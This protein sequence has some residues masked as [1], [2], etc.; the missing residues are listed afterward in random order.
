MPSSWWPG[1][2][3]FPWSLQW[4]RTDTSR[5]LAESGRRVSGS[6]PVR[7]AIG[8]GRC[9]AGRWRSRSQLRGATAARSRRRRADRQVRRNATVNR[10]ASLRSGALGLRA[11]TER[12]TRQDGVPW[13]LRHCATENRAPHSTSREDARMWQQSANC[14]ATTHGGLVSGGIASLSEIKTADD[15]ATDYADAP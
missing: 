14:S 8:R 13:L 7:P 6:T 4:A 12:L 11:V 1:F 3:Q 10:T 9:F 2:L 5:C 15:A